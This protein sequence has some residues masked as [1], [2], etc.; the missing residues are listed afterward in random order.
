MTGTL[1][2][3]GTRGSPLALAQSRRVA[4]ALG[5]THPCLGVE[6]VPVDTRGDRAAQ[7]PLTDVSDP[8]FFSAELDE[9]LLQ[10]RVDCCVHSLKDL[11]AARPAGIARA[12]LP[13]RENP[14]DVILWRRD[15]P[16]LLRAGTAL[17]LGSSSARRQHNV[18]DF[19]AGALPAGPQPAQLDFCNLRGPVDR[20]L[21][22]LALP[23]SSPDALD[24]VV[25]ALAGLA[26]LWNDA[27]G[28]RIIA[29]LLAGLRW[30]VLPLSRCPAAPG[31]GTLA[32]ECRADDGRSLEALRA[33]HD[34]ETAALVA[35]EASALNAVPVG[36]R[37]TWGA[38]AIRHQHLG[39]LCYLRGRSD[40]G[41]DERL[42]WRAPPRPAAPLAFDGIAWQRACTRQMCTPLPGLATLPVGS[43][44]FAAY[45]H[46]VEQQRLPADTRL[47]VSGVESWRQLAARGLWVEGCGDNLGF[48]ALKDTLRC[49]VL[50][51]PP[52][53][54]WTALTSR[55]ALPGWR[56]AGVGRVRATYDIN[57][58]ADPDTL[59]GLEAGAR[60][61]SHFYWS[62]PAQFEA[63]R[64]A[65]PAGAHHACGAGKTL[66]ALRA[67]GLD[68]VP[69]PNGREWHRWL[70]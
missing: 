40:A 3:L 60:Q 41:G 35:L 21:A 15:T 42:L 25:L 51:L 57:P 16:G 4:E 20:R 19:L 47:W 58:P 64:A 30:M 56:D 50:H 48:A 45:W 12:A 59:A 11:P 7:I 39:E 34:P 2:R 28:H 52:L 46:A 14:R 36:H 13:A 10:G 65:V 18:A 23:R 70:A 26:R 9:A 6:L 49:P 55:Q 31:Q 69:F 37:G 54:E 17:R 53:A 61:A 33:L 29:P 32:L 27:D 5:A 44:V 67:A 38:T 8:D 22:R 68:P 1:L 24:G 66:R 63:L 43:A 62:S